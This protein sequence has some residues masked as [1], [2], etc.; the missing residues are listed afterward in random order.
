MRPSSPWAEI[1]SRSSASA[2]RFSAKFIWALGKNSAPGILIGLAIIRPPLSPIIPCQS[3]KRSQ[4]SGMWSI[5]HCQSDWKSWCQLNC[6][7][8]CT[9]DAK[10]VTSAMSICTCVGVH[11]HVPETIGEEEDAIIHPILLFHSLCWPMLWRIRQRPD[12][13]LLIFRGS[14]SLARNQSKGLY[15]CILTSVAPIC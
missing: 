5:D 13:R 12:Y 2:S 15:P 4:N 8:S 14:L 3:H 1:A 6:V 10:S 9:K 7:F 11:K